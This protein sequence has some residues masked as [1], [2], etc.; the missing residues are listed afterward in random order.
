MKIVPISL[1]LFV[2]FCFVF[3]NIVEYFIAVTEQP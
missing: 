2:L 1:E 3:V